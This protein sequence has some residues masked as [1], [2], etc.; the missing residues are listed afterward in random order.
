M[1]LTFHGERVEGRYALFQTKGKNWM[2]HRMD[3]PAD[4]SA[5][6]MPER[7]APMLAKNGKLPRD[8]A[9]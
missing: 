6:P 3:P 1:I 5:E 2:I 4:P 9:A 8:D 7:I